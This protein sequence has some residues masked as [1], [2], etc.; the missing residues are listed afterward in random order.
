MRI[1]IYTRHK[2]EK[3]CFSLKG[4]LEDEHEVYIFSEDN[5]HN[6]KI[7]NSELY[8][9]YS[10]K[11]KSFD[12]IEI[13]DIISRCRVLRSIDRELSLMLINRSI[14]AIFGMIHHNNPDIIIAPRID[15]YYLDILNRICKKNKIQ[16]IGLWRS[17][18]K[19]SMFF[20][21]SRGE[22]NKVREPSKNEVKLL[23]TKLSGDNFKATS[24]K[25]SGYGVFD[26]IKRYCRLYVRALILEAIRL[27]SKNKFRYR[28]MATRFFV[29]EYRIPFHKVFY[30]YKDWEVNLQIILKGDRP[31]VFLALQV[32]PESTIDYYCEN[33]EFVNISDITPKIVSCFVDNGFDVVV[34]DHP[35]MLGSRNSDFIASLD[36]LSEHV[37]VIPSFVNSTYLI[38]ECDITYTWS[39]TVSVQ[40][41]MMNRKAICVCTPYHIS[42]DNFYKVSTLKELENLAKNPVLVD[43]ATPSRK[44][45]EKLAS[46][47]LSSHLKGDIFLHNKDMPVDLLSLKH[48]IQSII[49]NDN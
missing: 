8:F 17:A 16:F 30:S 31:N 29:D 34:K 14:Q 10:V 5:L 49:N 19:E 1:A 41:I 37:V 43:R 9:K 44:D 45:V 36:Q 35:N 13:D 46:H 23:I 11:K 7:I 39:G 38:K 20:L 27:L 4:L 25:L 12:D 24:L 47:I 48:N 32:N 15:N 3:F 6:K 26:S 2:L 18:F 21:T 40:A 42:M 28:E 22:F 33:L